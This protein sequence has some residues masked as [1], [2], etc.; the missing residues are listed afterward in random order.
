[1]IY[2]ENYKMHTH[3]HTAWVQKVDQLNSLFLPSACPA[4][5]LTDYEL[6]EAA[7]QLRIYIS[8]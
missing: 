3:T 6:Y 8:A 7:L 4:P 5:L 2:S 1:M